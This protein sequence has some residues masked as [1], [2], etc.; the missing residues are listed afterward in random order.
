LGCT[1]AFLKP[2][3]FNLDLR[4]TGKRRVKWRNIFP[5]ALLKGDAQ[6]RQHFI[7]RSSYVGLFWKNGSNNLEKQYLINV[8]L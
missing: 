6:F 3:I 7:Y 5:L 2:L 8:P 1:L 4:K